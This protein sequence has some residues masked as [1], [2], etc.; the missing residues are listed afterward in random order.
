M[1]GALEQSA[2]A[3][4]SAFALIGL[5][6]ATGAAK[7][8]SEHAPQQDITI[9][10]ERGLMHEKVAPTGRSVLPVEQISMSRVVS[11]KDLDLRNPSAVDELKRRVRIA[12]QEDCQYLDLPYQDSSAY[13]G[14]DPPAQQSMRACI[15]NTI[16]ESKP[17]VEKAI[18]LASR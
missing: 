18:Q 12:A 2:K 11:Y 3:C 15:R 1:I 13:V 10:G 9:V 5:I 16:N 7:A 8:Q 17:D 4:L 14:V 6:F